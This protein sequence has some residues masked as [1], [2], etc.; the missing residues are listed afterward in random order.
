MEAD[1]R[2][3]MG[4]AACEEGRRLEPPGEDHRQRG[5]TGQARGEA[6][7]GRSGCRSRWE[8]RT[9]L[10]WHQAGTRPVR[11]RRCGGRRWQAHGGGRR[12]NVETARDT[13][14]NGVKDRVCARAYVAPAG[15]SDS[16]RRR[17]PRRV[18][19]GRSGNEQRSLESLA[20]HAACGV[21]RRAGER[22]GA[23]AGSPRWQTMRSM[24]ALSRMAAITFSSPPRFG[25]RC[26]SNS[27]TRPAAARGRRRRRRSARA[28]RRAMS[29]GRWR[30]RIRCEAGVTWRAYARSGGKTK[31]LIPNL[32]EI[33]DL[34][35]ERLR[36]LGNSAAEV[37][38][39][40]EAK[41]RDHQSNQV[42]PCSAHQRGEPLHEFERTRHLVRRAVA[43]RRLQ[44][45]Y[46]P[47]PRVALHAF[48]GPV[49]AG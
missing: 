28:D 41:R 26:M 40:R 32:P 13:L 6:G 43:P 42:Q 45:R 19:P 16:R 4:D 23:R 21:G 15:T 3:E 39:L 1:C 9:A 24:T 47:S 38:P 35:M 27:N 25:Q 8:V 36:I 31:D 34:E 14:S 46:D 30:P 17:A 49:P 29:R 18:N 2:S 5:D 11:R 33:R 12:R 20:G 22:G 7:A 37:R 44:L 48:F 10:L